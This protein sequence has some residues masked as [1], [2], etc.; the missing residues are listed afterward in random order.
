MSSLYV[1]SYQHEFLDCELDELIDY[2]IYLKYAKY[3]S[4]TKSIIRNIE[5]HIKYAY[6]DIRKYAQELEQT[7]DEKNKQ[8]KEHYIEKKQNLHREYQNFF[9]KDVILKQI[10]NSNNP[11]LEEL[12]KLIKN[13]NLLEDN[14]NFNKEY[15][16]LLDK[17]D[18]NS[19]NEIISISK[20]EY[21]NRK[22]D[23]QNYI[24]DRYESI[25]R[26]EQILEEIKK[27]KSIDLTIFIN[28]N[29]SCQDN[30]RELLNYFEI[31]LLEEEQQQT[32]TQIN[33]KD[34]SAMDAFLRG[35]Q[36]GREMLRRR[37]QES[38]NLTQVNPNDSSAMDELRKESQESQKQEESE[39]EN[40]HQNVR[41]QK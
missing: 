35:Y 28:N 24:N 18:G 2:F 9:K 11:D 27:L 10:L 19:N 16:K 23:L 38:Q 32:Q 21:E 4:D 33:P 41:R 14:K 12:K 6:D 7:F 30:Y 25:K 15:K 13:N 36:E 5:N 1:N 39:R 40:K 20:E 31:D 17:F 22:K 34:S 37:Y 26:D 3:G 29:L 8:I